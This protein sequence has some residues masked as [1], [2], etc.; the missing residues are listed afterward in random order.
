M[1]QFSMRSMLVALVALALGAYSALAII[2]HAESKSQIPPD[3]PLITD[4]DSKR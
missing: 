2:R 4:F 3:R 1:A